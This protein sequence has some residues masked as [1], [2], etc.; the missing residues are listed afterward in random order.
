MSRFKNHMKTLAQDGDI[1]KVVKDKI[2]ETNKFNDTNTHGLY[3]FVPGKDYQESF[4]KYMSLP[5]RRKMPSDKVCNQIWGVPTNME[6]FNMWHDHITGIGRGDEAKLIDASNE[7]L[8]DTSPIKRSDLAALLTPYEIISKGAYNINKEDNYYK[9][10][11]EIDVLDGTDITVKDWYNAYKTHM[12]GI[13]SDLWEKYYFDWKATVIR[14]NNDLK[15][16]NLDM[17][18]RMRKCQSLLEL[19][20]VP[21]VDFEESY[22]IINNINKNKKDIDISDIRESAIS[23][24][25]TDNDNAVFLINVNANNDIFVP[26][27]TTDFNNI[28]S[29]NIVDE[30]VIKYNANV[31][32]RSFDT[33][34]IVKMVSPYDISILNETLDKVAVAPTAK[35]TSNQIVLEKNGF[36]ATTI[37]NVFL[38]ILPI[39]NVAMVRML[40]CDSFIIYKDTKYSDIDFDKLNCKIK[41]GTDYD[42]SNPLDVLC[43]SPNPLTLHAVRDVAE[44]TLTGY[45]LDYFNEMCNVVLGTKTPKELIDTVINENALLKKAS[46]E[47]I[48]ESTNINDAVI[49]EFTKQIQLLR[50]SEDKLNLAYNINNR[51]EDHIYNK[52]HDNNTKSE[53]YKLREE[54]L[55]IMDECVKNGGSLEDCISLHEGVHINTSI[56]YKTNLLKL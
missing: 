11:G 39:D 47:A 31:I 55:L 20:W 10:F 9:V 8:K 5:H 56:L 21:N 49:I 35:N 4:D 24:T 52:S 18:S 48:N 50:E 6:L 15:D 7:L 36:N 12:S 45:N 46:M 1:V 32:L 28:Y 40:Y 2:D 53:L 30:C 16:Q 23:E 44:A 37:I 42:K 25:E 14:L 54:V 13:S 34:T 22:I 29:V 27:I 33:V 17:N 41:C 26:Y 19:G 38:H 51:L 43:K 3:V